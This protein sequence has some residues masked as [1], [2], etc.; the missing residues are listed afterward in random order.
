MV[1]V[2][3][4]MTIN[5]NTIWGNIFWKNGVHPSSRVQR[6]VESMSRHTEAVPV[7]RGGPTPY[8]HFMVVF[9]LICHSSV[10]IHIYGTQNKCLV[11]FSSTCTVGVFGV[12][13]DCAD[14][15]THGQMMKFTSH[16]PFRPRGCGNYELAFESAA[17]LR[18]CL[19]IYKFKV[20]PD[21]GARWKVRGWPNSSRG[22]HKCLYQITW[23]SVQ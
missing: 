15:R 14:L 8:W 18:L 21:D 5:Q 23:Q 4:R 7:A 3:S 11:C 2:S 22:G 16:G 17:S 1:V 19:E 12:H 13:T 20:W 6:L 10:Y 9:P